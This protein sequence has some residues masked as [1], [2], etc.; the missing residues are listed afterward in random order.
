M[1]EEEKKEEVFVPLLERVD[2]QINSLNFIVQSD[3]GKYKGINI[4]KTDI[5]KETKADFLLCLQKREKAINELR[6][7]EGVE[8][9]CGGILDE[10]AEI[11]EK[12]LGSVM[13]G[14]RK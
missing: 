8:L 5:L 2:D 9:N 12:F 14:K 6:E 10:I 13:R 3:N 1:N 11:D 7:E 4:M